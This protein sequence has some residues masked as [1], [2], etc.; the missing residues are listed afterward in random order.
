MSPEFYEGGLNILT[1]PQTLDALD[2]GIR[3]AHIL[4]VRFVQLLAVYLDFLWIYG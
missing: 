2:F 1:R 3:H 4:N